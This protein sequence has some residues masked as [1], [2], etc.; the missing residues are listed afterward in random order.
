MLNHR[1]HNVHFETFCFFLPAGLGATAAGGSC[2]GAPSSF[3]EGRKGRGDVKSAF[4]SSRGYDGTCDTVVKAGKAVVGRR[5]MN[6]YESS[7]SVIVRRRIAIR[8]HSRSH[9]RLSALG[10]D[11]GSWRLFRRATEN[12]PLGFKRS[13][14]RSICNSVNP[15]TWLPV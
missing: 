13:M 15:F 12:D 10:R 11:G 2:G 3:R 7:F 9:S 5:G 1:R 14:A 8:K 4:F 6:I